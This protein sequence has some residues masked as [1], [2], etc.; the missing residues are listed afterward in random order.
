MRTRRGYTLIEMLTVIMLLSSLLGI[1]SVL[2]HRMVRAERA[3]REALAE[4]AMLARLADEFRRDA[5]RARSATLDPDGLT[6]TLPDDARI[7][8]RI[9]EGAAQVRRHVTGADGTVGETT[10]RPG[11]HGL[12]RLDLIEDEG[13][14]TVA[15]LAIGDPDRVSA[16]EV[17]VE[18]VVGL[19]HRFEAD[20]GRP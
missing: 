12:P 13:G 8:Y 11:R 20:G 15:V 14:T 2:I 19:D 18:A 6:L 1:G 17:R 7:E 5:H 16:A 3:G 10:F 4:S 9:D